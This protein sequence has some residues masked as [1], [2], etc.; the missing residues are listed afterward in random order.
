MGIKAL[1]LNV[2]AQM[3]TVPLAVPVGKPLGT[4]AKRTVAIAE[5]AETTWPPESEAQ[6]QRFGQFHARL[7]PFIDER[8]WTAAGPGLLLSVHA[9][10]CEILPDGGVKTIRV[11]T[12]D[13]RPIH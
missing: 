8:V 13:V 9:M 7:F 1:A 3:Q 6:A 5:P 2:L 4:Q 11:P 12:E 10:Q